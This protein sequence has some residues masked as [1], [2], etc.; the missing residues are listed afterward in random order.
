MNV[1]DSPPGITRPSRPSSCSGLRTSTTS[2]A[3]APQH[4]RVLAEVSLHGEN[5]DP[6][7]ASWRHGIARPL[8]RTPSPA[9]AGAALAHEALEMRERLG[10]R[11]AP[12]RRREV[13]ARRARATRRTPR[14]ASPSSAASVRSSRSRWC[15]RSR[16]ARP[17]GSRIGSRVPGVGD[18][19]R[20]LL[21]PRQRLEVVAERV[22]PRVRIEPDRR[23]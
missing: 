18:P 14:A 12:E 8:R 13:V 16:A 11:E 7:A 17:A 20:Q 19:R 10:G 3:E 5:A 1:V 23:A 2:R 4:L 21:D 6:E 9:R 15:S 22:G